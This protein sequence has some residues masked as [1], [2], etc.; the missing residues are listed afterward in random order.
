MADD[1]PDALE[2]AQSPVLIRQGVLRHQLSQPLV[3]HRDI[4]LDARQPPLEQA[5]TTGSRISRS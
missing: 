5:M 1:G 2:G 4:G 3:Q